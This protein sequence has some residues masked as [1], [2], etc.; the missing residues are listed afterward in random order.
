MIVKEIH[1][2]ICEVHV[3]TCVFVVIKCEI[4]VIASEI[5]M[6]TCDENSSK[7]MRCG[8]CSVFFN[9]YVIDATRISRFLANA[10]LNL[11]TSR[12][13]RRFFAQNL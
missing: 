12:R 7:H 5:Y 6:I 10:L 2:I 1:V 8:T 11:L 4:H 3:I 9:S 13:S